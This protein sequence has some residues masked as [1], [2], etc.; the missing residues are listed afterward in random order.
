MFQL[1]LQVK[2]GLPERCHGIPRETVQIRVPSGA[3]ERPGSQ[4]ESRLAL[5]CESLAA[6]EAQS[7]HR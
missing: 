3:G 7:N 4:E 2:S 6:S 1:R 5:L